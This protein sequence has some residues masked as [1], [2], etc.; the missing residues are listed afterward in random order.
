MKFDEWKQRADVDRR[1][2]LTNATVFK[3]NKVNGQYVVNV[4]FEEEVADLLK[5]YRLLSGIGL[6]NTDSNATTLIQIDYLKERYPSYRTLSDVLRTYDLT[7]GKITPEIEVLTHQYPMEE[8][9]GKQQLVEWMAKNNITENGGRAQVQ[10]MIRFG[11]GGGP[12]GS[13][14]TRW[15]MPRRVESYAALLGQTIQSFERQVDSLC[16]KYAELQRLVEEL[17]TCPAAPRDFESAL[18]SIQRV[19]NDMTLEG[20]GNGELWMQGFRQQVDDVLRDRVRDLIKEWTAN[21]TRLG[22]GGSDENRIGGAKQ[23]RSSHKIR[24]RQRGMI[25]EPPLQMARYHWLAQLQE[26]T[27]VITKQM[28][29]KTS[30][31]ASALQTGGQTGDNSMQYLLDDMQPELIQAQGVIEYEIEKAQ[32]NANMWM[33]YQQL[34]A[35]TQDDVLEFMT[36]THGDD[37]TKW[38]SLLKNVAGS[39]EELDNE[40]SSSN[41]SA[42]TIDF[43]DVQTRVMDKYDVWHKGLLK[44]FAEKLQVR[45]PQHGLSSNKMVLITSDCDAMRVHEHQMAL[46]TSYLMPLRWLFGQDGTELWYQKVNNARDTLEN[47]SIETGDTMQAI[48]FLNSV[49]NFKDEKPKWGADVEAFTKGEKLL[50]RARTALP[51][52]SSTAEGVRPLCR[53]FPLPSLA[54]TPPVR[55]G[56]AGST[57]RRSRTSGRRSARSSTSVRRR[58]R[59]RSRSCR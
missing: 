37:L 48:E 17:R 44:A 41:D 11:T 9:S 53:V 58:W 45:T 21:V 29:I 57:R 5:D 16:K 2:Q 28:K 55:C 19:I 36:K 10:D 3:V 8:S 4:N 56:R 42:I 33:R 38:L 23:V 1:G 22:Q 20:N 15:T 35:G 43:K 27:Q 52:V 25:L 54:E 47:F 14:G 7:L 51:Q 32:E 31:Y 30:T 49:E 39:R 46:I 6:F 59:R 26:C 40:D 50:L 18:K 24:V 12:K 13:M 34:W